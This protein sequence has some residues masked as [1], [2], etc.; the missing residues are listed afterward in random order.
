MSKT[1]QK[2]Q[3][4]I[5]D[6][7][8]S[9]T[10]DKNE[11]RQTMAHSPHLPFIAH[12]IV[13]AYCPGFLITTKGT[14]HQAPNPRVLR[15]EAILLSLA[16]AFVA[17]HQTCLFHI[18]YS[19]WGQQ[20]QM[21][22]QPRLGEWRRPRP[23]VQDACMRLERAYLLVPPLWQES[24]TSFQSTSLFW[25][26]I[27]FSHHFNGGNLGPPAVC[28]DSTCLITGQNTVCPSATYISHYGQIWNDGIINRHS[29]S[30]SSWTLPLSPHSRPPNQPTRDSE[31]TTKAEPQSRP[32]ST[33][34]EDAGCEWRFPHSLS[35]T[36]AKACGREG[37]RSV[38]CVWATSHRR[39][40]DTS[41]CLRTRSEEDQ[42]WER[43]LGWPLCVLPHHWRLTCMY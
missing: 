33:V 42:E 25:I 39:S 12:L 13:C 22:F 28:P 32:H 41:W 21:L 40:T 2:G 38:V 20:T 4:S 35:S 23:G 5:R 34:S 19:W 9:R 27:N 1:L 3:W 30:H 7:K 26:L 43:R 6:R 17:C 31:C 14:P 18:Y 10:G 29:F 37:T 36:W 8:G 16:I 15:Q 11:E 24:I